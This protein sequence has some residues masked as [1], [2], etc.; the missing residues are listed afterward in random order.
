[1]STSLTKAQEL[2]TALE[3]AYLAVVAGAS[4]TISVGGNTRTFTR[5]NMK[6]LRSEMEYWSSYIAKIN[7]GQR[8][9]PVKF[10]TPYV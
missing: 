7:S 6:E 10:G 4:Y 2:Y 9:V 8:G 3:A 1:M 5:Q